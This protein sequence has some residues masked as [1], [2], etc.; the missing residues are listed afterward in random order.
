M[1]AGALSMA[2]RK[3]TAASDGLP[4]HRLPS[5]AHPC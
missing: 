4:A 5:T 3:R 2:A 1:A